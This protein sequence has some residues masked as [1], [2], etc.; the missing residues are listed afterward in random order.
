MGLGPE[1]RGLL[2]RRLAAAGRYG[3]FPPHEAV[4]WPRR[5]FEEY[6][7]ALGRLLDEENKRS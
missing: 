2:F 6:M 4:R 3:K 1:R 7:E 5:H